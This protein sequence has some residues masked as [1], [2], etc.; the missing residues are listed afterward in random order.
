MTRP[1]P[2]RRLRTRLA[3]LHAGLAFACSVVLLAM[4]DLPL[5]TA[6][7]T[8]Q[9]PAPGQPTA[10]VTAGQTT[11]NLPDLLLYSAVAL[12]V[13]AA[14]SIALGW[15]IAGRALRPLH[16]ITLSARTMSASTLNHRLR[17]PAAYREFTELADTLD[18]LLQRLHESITAQRQ[19]VA[20]A[21][22]ELRTPL[23]VQ[24]TLLQLTLADPDATADTLRSTCHELLAL[25]QQQEHLIN[26]LLTL[27]TGYQGIDHRERFDLA[28]L[29]RNVVLDHRLQA[30]DRGI[31][32]RTTLTPTAVTG[33][34]RLAASLVTNLVDNALRHNIPG[35]TVEITTTAPGR[36]TVSNTGTEIPPAEISRMFQPFQR[37]GTDRTNQTSGHGLGLAIVAAIAQAHGAP[38]AAHAR[39]DG[40]LQITVDFPPT[41]SPQ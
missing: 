17:V 22:H 3:L 10:P 4:V 34:A 29:T 30:Q 28:D 26:A 20:N 9:R 32:V 31:D 8:T 37:L 33:D 6:S 13:L 35:G 7:H 5:L 40:G 12:G 38:L 25:G 2:R 19:F 39:P 27:A 18:S 1:P 14:V 36:L 21:S 11:S 16:V 23:T 15:L 24:R 41:Q